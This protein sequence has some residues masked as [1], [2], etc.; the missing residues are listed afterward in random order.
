MKSLT[1]VVFFS[2][3]LFSM[4]ASGHIPASMPLKVDKIVVEKHKRTMILY[5]QDKVVK[6]YPISLGFNPLGHKAR[7]GDGKTPEGSYQITYKNPQSRYHLSLKLSYPSIED[8]KRADTLGVKPGVDIVIHGVGSQQVKR[9]DWTHGCIAVSNHE[10][11][12]IFQ[13]AQVGTLV[14]IF[15]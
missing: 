1:V 3:I 6:Y 10:M 7:E 15:P 2:G 8:K 13:F 4:G 14:H 5:Q 12:E 11:E 9:G